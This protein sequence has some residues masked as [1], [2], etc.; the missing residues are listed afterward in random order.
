M[1]LLNFQRNLLNNTS[2]F[3]SMGCCGSMA[4]A[5]LPPFFHHLVT[6]WLSQMYTFCLD[7]SAQCFRT[8]RLLK[9]YPV[10]AHSFLCVAS[11]LTKTFPVIMFCGTQWLSC[12]LR[13][14]LLTLGFSVAAQS[15]HSLV[16]R[17]KG[18]QTSASLLML[19]KQ[20]QVQ[21]NSLGDS[22]RMEYGWLSQLD[23]LPLD[24]VWLSV[25]VLCNG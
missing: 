2:F 8:N 9:I 22:D 13:C 16:P 4:I 10:L 17:Q 23:H 7:V 18:R 19:S 25:F 3:H 21:W 24:S 20:G 1:K 14:L 11:L 12:L 15:T 5:F 6:F